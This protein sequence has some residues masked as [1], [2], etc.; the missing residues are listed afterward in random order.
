MRTPRSIDAAAEPGEPPSTSK[1]MPPVDRR[2]TLTTFS[3]FRSIPFR[4]FFLSSVV[5]TLGYQM[6][7]VALG[8]LVYVLTG[9][10]LYL[11]TITTVQSVCQTAIS[12]ISGVI[13]DR[14]ERRNYIIGVRLITVG[15]ALALAILVGSH[16]VTILDL[17]IAAAIFGLA[18]GLNGPARQALMAQ[19]VGR[20]LLMNAVSLMSGGMNL[21][22][23]LGPAAAGFLIGVIGVQGIYGILVVCY[24]AVIVTLL[25]VPRQPV[26]P[27]AASRN[28]VGD[29]TAGLSYSYNEP[30]VFGLL[31]IGTVPLFF[32][33]PYIPLL[34]IFAEQIWH[35]GA[36]GYGVLSA[37]PGV[38][39]L[40]GALGVASFSSV[41]KKGRL[42]LTG[43]LLYGI[44][45]GGFCHVAERSGRGGLPRAGGCHGGDLLGYREQCGPD[46]HPERDAWSRHEPLS[47]VIRDQRAERI[48]GQRDRRGGWG[49]HHGRRLWI[50]GGDRFPG[51]LQTA[52]GSWNAVSA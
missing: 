18:F 27:R 28:V 47:D 50:A 9:S 38:G 24:L 30:A 46:D 13:A 21:M 44:I 3:A 15:V 6:Q 31:L 29:L 49:S 40:V 26:E 22:R 33:M 16:H 25:P 48:A 52:A 41:R 2:F 12:P 7:G 17:I 19:I 8:W 1:T 35:S 43:S 10:A 42:V 23:I 34:P 51:D 20:D 5:G 32:A 4:W 45:A 36:I 11:G 14:V 39:G 37:A